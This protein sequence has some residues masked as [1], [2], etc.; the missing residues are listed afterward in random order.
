MPSASER[1][2][3]SVLL[4]TCPCLLRAPRP[5][6]PALQSRSQW[7]GGC[8]AAGVLCAL[9]SSGTPQLRSAVEGAPGQEGAEAHKGPA[10]PREGTRALCPWCAAWHQAC[11]RCPGPGI[12]TAQLRCGQDP[13]A[14][15]TASGL[16]RAFHKVAAWR[17]NHREGGQEVDGAVQGKAGLATG[18]VPPATQ[19]GPWART[20]RVWCL[21][22]QGRALTPMC[23]SG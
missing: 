9:L 19:P 16:Q 17:S 1:P 10:G 13:D 15:C 18:T 20:Q 8:W 2:P 14:P 7:L 4:S 6:R 23:D 12:E 22:G 21:A 5:H 3:W 11:P